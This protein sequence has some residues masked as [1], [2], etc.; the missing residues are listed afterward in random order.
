MKETLTVKCNAA[1]STVENSPP[2]PQ[3]WFHNLRNT[4]AH[5][6]RPDSLATPSTHHP[7]RPHSTFPA[8]HPTRGRYLCGKHW[9]WP[10]QAFNPFNSHSPLASISPNASS[11]HLGRAPTNKLFCA[12][13]TWL[14]TA[15]VGDLPLPMSGEKYANAHRAS[16]SC[17]AHCGRTTAR[18]SQRLGYPTKD[19]W[20]QQLMQWTTDA[21]A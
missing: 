6:D 1:C 11:S 5:A 12:S 16:D 4:I 9:Q 7:L 10:M 19:G 13:A 8:L 2:S 17:V 20:W 18:R 15:Y 21:R 14:A 3:T